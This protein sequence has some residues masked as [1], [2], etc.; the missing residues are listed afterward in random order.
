[1]RLVFL[2]FFLASCGDTL[3]TTSSSYY[4]IEH[5]KDNIWVCHNEKSELHQGPCA[6]E[7]YEPGDQS[8]FCW[9][10]DREECKNPDSEYLELCQIQEG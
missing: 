7:C 9:L 1:M 5:D 2:F 10:L 3:T 8:A 6:P 4:N